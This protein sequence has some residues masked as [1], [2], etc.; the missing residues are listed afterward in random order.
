VSFPGFPGTKRGRHTVR[1]LYQDTDQAKIVHHATYF[2]YLEAARLE[3]WRDN[4]F[5]YDEFEKTTGLALPVAEAQMRYRAAARFDDVIEVS[6]WVATATRASVWFEATICRAD[7]VL[8]EAK[9]RLAC[10]TLGEGQIRRIPDAL[11]DACLEPGH[12][13]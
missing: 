7:V 1:V 2:R 11:L 5:S 6:T 9:V 10:A 4:G 3:L 8:V 13:V 12:G